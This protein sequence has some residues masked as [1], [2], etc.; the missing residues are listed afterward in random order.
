MEGC[1]CSLNGLKDELEGVVS[2]DG[3]DVIKTILVSCVT[4]V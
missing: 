3:T 4:F 2:S 1:E